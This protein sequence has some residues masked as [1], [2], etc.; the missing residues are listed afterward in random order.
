MMI[1]VSSDATLWKYGVDEKTKIKVP[2]AR[3]SV[4]IVMAEPALSNE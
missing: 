3:L 4:V 1:G 2:R